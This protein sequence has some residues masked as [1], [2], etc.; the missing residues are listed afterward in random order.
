MKK[1]YF[2]KNYLLFLFI[3]IG[4]NLLAQT[5]LEPKAPTL[6]LGLDGI[7]FTKG[8]LD[9]QLIM[10]IIAEKQ[11]ELKV[12]TIQ[13]VF[14]SKVEGAGGT[15]YSFTDNIVR[16]LVLE[17]NPNV[18][19]KKILEN[20]VNMVFV[21]T[22]L[23]YYLKSINKTNSLIIKSF[24]DLMDDFYV[25]YKDTNNKIIALDNFTQLSE[26]AADIINN[27]RNRNNNKYLVPFERE[28][29]KWKFKKRIRS[30]NKNHK[31]P[32]LKIF[33]NVRVKTKQPEFLIK[34]LGFLVDMTSE[35]VKQ[36][37]KLKALGIMQISYSETYDY[38]NYYK[39]ISDS[40]NVKKLFEHMHLELKKFTNNIGYINYLIVNKNNSQVDKFYEDLKL[41][42]NLKSN[43]GLRNSIF[44]ADSSK[45]SLEEIS[46]DDFKSYF[47]KSSKVKLDSLK[48]NLNISIF[49]V[50]NNS[51]IKDSV[52][53]IMVQDLTNL[54]LHINKVSRIFNTDNY[55]IN[56]SVLSD[57]IY[58]FENDFKNFLIRY[59]YLN[60][61]NI[62]L[63]DNIDSLAFSFYQYLDNSDEIP[64]LNEN[65]S[66]NLA[67]LIANCY[68]FDKTKTFSDYLNLVD[69]ISDVF[70]D[71]KIK[72]SLSAITTFIK[73]YTT[74]EK[75]EEDKEI[76]N[77]HLEDFLVRL[78]NVK[79]FE[80]KNFEFLLTVG[81]NNA[82][83]NK[84]LTLSDGSNI[85][86]L[87]FVSEK[88]GFKFKFVDFEYTKARNVGETF[89]LFGKDYVRT[90]PPRQATLSN[91][92]LLAYAS[93]V[94]YNLVDAKTSKEFNMPLIGA[95]LGF[96]FFNGLDFNLSAGIP[97]IS[98][99]PIGFQN[100]Y[101][102]FGFDIQFIE[103]YKRLKQKNDNKKYQEKISKAKS[104]ANS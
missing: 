32:C 49:N 27:K 99:Q 21:I 77:F 61:Y 82:V 38:L 9:A 94:L 16:E 92:H 97:I 83:F 2:I 78:Q 5:E 19:T 42:T 45:S 37:E 60:E 54:S 48:R 74:F 80:Y 56:K 104:T 26:T 8:S 11:Q 33:D 31:E 100:Y 44:K 22:F 57:F 15:I 4:N 71:D 101:Y 67:K 28:T 103:Y 87:G 23:D 43:M 91:I 88:I 72:S 53:Q 40:E 24:N 76:I 62:K 98:N 55:S 58:V 81:V 79:P 90:A 20:T 7:N 51:D 73:D 29:R 84:D 12:K 3:L 18:R 52:K 13:N 65:Y 69:M 17:S 30:Y 1:F 6:Q 85:R 35:V 63:L 86:N 34:F 25:G 68:Q 59:S 75:N 41:K 36:D 93:G 39:K 96:S 102:G 14:L 66:A 64:N 89:K 95:G 47:F 46:F 50:I 70:P 10:E